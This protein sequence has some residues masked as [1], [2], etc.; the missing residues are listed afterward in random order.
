LL[1]YFGETYTKENCGSCDN[2][3]H[4]KKSFDGQEEICTVLET[5]KSVKE[6]FASDHIA[7]II[8]GKA[9]NA[10]KLHGHDQLEE[11]GEG[12]D[13]DVKFWTAIIRQSILN[14]FLS[15]EIETYGTLKLTD[16]GKAFM[17]KPFKVNVVEDNEFGDTESD[18]D[19][20]Y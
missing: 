18:D 9:E 16:K 7:N 5:V 13:H 6:K 3:L 2:C 10:V 12:A 14:G 4:P 17:K 19:E 11:F 15:K 20:D 8:T 1:N